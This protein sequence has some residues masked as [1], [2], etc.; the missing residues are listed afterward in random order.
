MVFA[1]RG[2]DTVD[3]GEGQDY[4]EGGPGGDVVN[5]QAGDDDLVGGS[6]TPA[7]GSGAT[8]VGQ[9]DGGDTLGGGPDQDV[10]LGDNG[11]LTRSR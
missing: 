11:A 6:Y 4:G 9:P 1:Q 7:G 10:V 2:A 8:R 3:L 5:G